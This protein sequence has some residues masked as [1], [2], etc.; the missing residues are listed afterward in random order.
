MS[1]ASTAPIARI[2][3]A[4]GMAHPNLPIFG[5]SPDNPIAADVVEEEEAGAKGLVALLA[6]PDEEAARQVAP[7]NFDAP[8]LI[9]EKHEHVAIARVQR[10][11]LAVDDHLLPELARD[12]PIAGDAVAELV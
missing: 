1:D 10:R 7:G 2:G 11:V 5:G 6:V 9:R 8:I 12:A 3:R 4:P